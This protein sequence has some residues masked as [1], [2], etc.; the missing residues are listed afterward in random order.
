MAEDVRDT[1]AGAEAAPVTDSAAM[2]LALGGASRAEADA[3]LKDQR[4]LIADQ[5]H[6]MH[7][8]LKQLQL[9]LWEKR[10]GFVLRLATAFMGLAVA[11]GLAFLIWDAAHSNELI[12][13]PFSVPP[14]MA[15][16]GMTGDVVAGE[17]VDRIT[18]MQQ[19]FPNSLRAPQSFANSFGGGIKLEIP[20]T[21]VSLSELDRFLREKLGNN[22]HV[23]G[24]LIHTPSGLK[25]TARAGAAGSDSVQGADNDM[26]AL[27]QR[28]AEAVYG[29]TQPYRYGIYLL[30]TGRLEE[31][32]AV[33]Q[34]LAKSGSVQEQA[35]A[36]FAL[37]QT[38]RATELDPQ[39]AVALMGTAAG[40]SDGGQWEQSLARYRKALELLASPRH[41][42]VR[43]DRISTARM[44]ADVGIAWLLGAYHDAAIEWSDPQELQR[45]I[46]EGRS[47]GLAAYQSSEH[48]LG[49]ARATMA[50]PLP[51]SPG[52]AAQ[53][54]ISNASARILI[55]FMA[56]DWSGVMRA[57][58]VLEPLVAKTPKSY[59]GFHLNTA[60]YAAIAEAR[61]GRFDAA[62]G[63]VKRMPA[64]CYLCLIA[65]G[66]VADMQG[67]H[68]RADWWLAR[69]VQQAPSSPFAYFARGEALF[70]RGQPDAA[71]A[72][73]KL[74][75]Q[76]GPHFADALTGW[77]EALM[78]QN[79]SL[80]ALAKFAEAEKYAP[81]WGRL[82][83]KWGEALLYASKRDEA[84]IQFTHAAALDLTPSEKAELA[85]A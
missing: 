63:R 36:D 30:D 74:A 34:T 77:G 51:D 31:S 18:E 20:E 16:K 35:W 50:D 32:K 52:R 81:H 37:G 40:A 44:R 15:A 59:A 46:F 17:I 48:D 82:H 70:Q 61:L 6:H 21:G 73:F 68:A 78:A 58:A 53:G 11:A 75:N 38:Q 76:K 60:F 66:Q 84:R 14:D 19:R 39:N 4:I 45:Q 72:Q 62:E 1:D 56:Q 26:D 29:R 67:Q 5:R 41:G 22:T 33:L 49:A 57:N 23:G 65:H 43:T 42:Q 85:E 2:S 55:A 79:K 9:G 13:D 28:L 83:L 64:D 3:F 71:I 25:L 10:M 69:A 54:V 7:E 80:L 27:L 47:A 12:V 8:Q 24:A